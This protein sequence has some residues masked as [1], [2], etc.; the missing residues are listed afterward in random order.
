MII[1]NSKSDVILADKS[2]NL[3]I[4]KLN[5]VAEWRVALRICLTGYCA[6]RTKFNTVI[7]RS[8]WRQLSVTVK[9]NK[10]VNSHKRNGTK[11]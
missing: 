6:K 8:N 7:M 2:R 1:F 10:K 11:N 4:V 5:F 3:V 9:H